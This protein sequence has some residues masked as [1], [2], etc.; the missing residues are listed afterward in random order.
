MNA[1]S[2]SSQEVGTFSVRPYVGGSCGVVV[3]VDNGGGG[4]Y[5]VAAGADVQYMFN[6]WFGLSV[7]GEYLQ[8]GFSYDKGTLKDHTFKAD[9]VAVP[10]MANFYVCKGLAVKAGLSPTFL[11]KSSNEELIVD[12]KGDLNKFDLTANVGLSYEFR[13]GIVLETRV[14]AGTVKLNKQDDRSNKATQGIG[15]LTVGY[16]F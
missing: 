5:G 16:R 13:N 10:V 9:Y 4:R 14:N 7:G 2:R 6:N 8:G 11:V 12:K 3:N 15:V 1:Q